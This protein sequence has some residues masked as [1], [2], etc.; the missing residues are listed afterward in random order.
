MN[1]PRIYRHKPVQ[2]ILLVFIFIL[3]FIPLFLNTD[4][5]EALIRIIF[6]SMLGI[7]FVSAL[8]STT[9]KT[10]TSDLEISTQTLLGKRS[11]AWNEISR[12]SGAGSRIKLHNLP[13]DITVSPSPQ[14]PG[15]AEV[16][17]LIGAKRPD[18]FNPLEY[19]EMKKGR[20]AVFPFAMLVILFTGTLLGYGTLLFTSPGTPPSLFIPLIFITVIALVFLG[21][22]LSSPRAVML[23]GRSMCLKYPFKEKTLPADG[24]ASIELRFTQTRNG[25]NYF[26]LL[27][28]TDR[29]SVR[30]SGLN[31]GLPIVYL[32][33]KNWHKKNTGRR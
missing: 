5:D 19:G 2:F 21:V 13:G 20:A 22:L 10:I 12:V 11:L 32:V 8:Y 24:I 30:L 31:P 16:I 4:R 9:V 6:I 14:L 25:K 1:E 15:Y 28:Q 29:K 7:A 17:E 3:I 27:T 23:D 33:L 26:I 18:L